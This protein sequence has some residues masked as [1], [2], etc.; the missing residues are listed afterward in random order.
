MLIISDATKAAYGQ[1][2]GG[3]QEGRLQWQEKKRPIEGESTLLSVYICL[4]IIF[5]IARSHE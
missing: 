4:F 5:T 3:R 1:Q 2:A